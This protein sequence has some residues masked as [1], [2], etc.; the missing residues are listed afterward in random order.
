MGDF[1]FRG[2]VTNCVCGTQARCLHV[3]AHV[4]AILRPALLDLVDVRVRGIAQDREV[5]NRFS[6]IIRCYNRF[7]YLKSNA[8]KTYSTVK[9]FVSRLPPVSTLDRSGSRVCPVRG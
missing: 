3:G 1:L 6:I 9:T 8:Q 7:T 2:V 4:G 5:I